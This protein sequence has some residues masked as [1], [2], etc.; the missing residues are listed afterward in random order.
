M[1]VDDRKNTFGSLRRVGLMLRHGRNWLTVEEHHVGEIQTDRPVFVAADAIVV[2]DIQAPKV[3]VSGLL[4]GLVRANECA[5]ENGGQIW[6]DVFTKTLTIEADCKIHG[7][8]TTQD[9]NSLT[10]S[11]MPDLPEDVRSGIVDNMELLEQEK[12]AIRVSIWRQLQAEA[13]AALVSRLATERDFDQRLEE[14]AGDSIAEASELREKIEILQQQ[15]MV[16]D[17]R[18]ARLQETIKM[19]DDQLQH[20][21]GEL[22]DLQARLDQRDQAIEELEQ[23]RQEDSFRLESLEVAKKSLLSQLAESDG[24]VRA[25]EERAENLESALQD[26]L[27]HTSEME[28]SLVRWQELADVNEN[29]VRELENEIN[30]LNI[31]L[32]ESNQ[33]VEMLR[34]QREKVEVEWNQADIELRESEEVRTALETS[35]SQANSELDVL[36]QESQWLRTELSALKEQISSRPDEYN[37]ALARIAVAEGTVREL[38]E[39]LKNSQAVAQAN[40]EKLLWSQA[41]HNEA[42]AEFEEAQQT[43]RERDEFIRLMEEKLAEKQALADKW[44]NSVSRMTD[45]LYDAEKK[46]KEMEAR[47]ANIDTKD[48]DEKKALRE[49]ARQRQLQMEAFQVEID[50]LHEQISSQGSRLAEVQ[51]ALIERDL[52]IDASQGEIKA[53]RAEIERVKRLAT[54]RIR[55][56]EADQQRTKDELAQAER[57]LSDLSAWLERRRRRGEAVPTEAESPESE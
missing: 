39:Q 26:S 32:N 47:L 45:L 29:Q 48:D 34:A 33:V 8:V 2:G 52:A 46:L 16:I 40:Y 44:Q 14:L 22:A 11:K 28:E 41:A 35:L 1:A 19:R 5:I 4:Y 6:G 50:D 57:K 15:Q 24:R 53:S 7:W 25:L 51:A 18:I 20:R 31:Q 37:E 43:I 38:E 56:V 3:V 55:R 49:L 27:Q 42:I 23:S 54:L 12:S 13:A 10:I 9:E 17:L 30:L 36:R 21:T